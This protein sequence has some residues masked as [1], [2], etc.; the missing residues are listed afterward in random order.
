M[1]TIA[2][3]ARA[4]VDAPART[5]A[6]ASAP[7]RSP[8]SGHSR[9]ASWPR[10]SGAR[11]GRG[12]R[13]D[14]RARRRR[15]PADPRDQG[16]ALQTVRGR[17]SRRSRGALGFGRTRVPRRRARA[18]WPPCSTGSRRRARVDASARGARHPA[19]ARARAGSRSTSARRARSRCAATR[20]AGSARSRRTSCSA[21][22]IG[23]LFGKQ[24]QAYPRYGSEKKGLPTSYNL[25]I[26][27]EPI[28]SHGELDRVDFVPLHDVAAFAL[29]E[30]LHG[31]VDGGTVFVQSSLTDPEAIW[32]VHPGGGPR[33]HRWPGASGSRRSTRP[34][35]RE[36]T[37][38]AGGPGAADAGRRAGRRL[39]A[40]LARFAADA[41]MDREALLA[42]VGARLRAILRQ[43]R[44]R[45]VVEPTWR[46]S[47]RPIDGV[48]DVKPAIST[49]SCRSWSL[50]GPARPSHDHAGR[51]RAPPLS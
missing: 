22:L 12:R 37:R 11:S 24:V 42:A 48:I 26:A 43:A 33:R 20:S 15:Q 34:R 25:T 31:L 8:R 23:E 2:D 13:A 14:R 6:R 4:V 16:R 35:L 27:D 44:G 28:R 17:G 47:P 45:R 19:P 21:T 46:S 41:G 38:P 5:G 9:P 32:A 36:V 29:G 30:P 7:L 49:K 39:P 1:G 50:A 18:T 40:G 3:T 10:C 51:S